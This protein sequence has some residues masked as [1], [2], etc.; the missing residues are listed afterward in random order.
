LR[1]FIEEVCAMLDY[2]GLLAAVVATTTA[3]EE[4]QSEPALADAGSAL[5][6]AA[7]NDPASLHLGALVGPLLAQAGSE[8]PELD[9]LRR[10]AA[11][12]GRGCQLAQGLETARIEFELS[13][14]RND[15]P[16]ALQVLQ[17][18]LDRLAGLHTPVKSL[19]AEVEV[20]RA[21]VDTLAHIASH[22][23]QTDLPS[24]QWDWANLFAGRRGFAFVQAMREG[25][26]G[27]RGRAFAAGAI[28]GYAG[29]VAGSAC[30]GAMVGGPR[31][32]H[33]F[34]DRLARNT[35]GMALR[36]SLPVPS[37]GELSVE[38]RFD[39]R[40]LPILPSDLKAQLSSALSAAYPDRPIPDL[41]VAHQ[42]MIEHLELLTGFALPNLPDPPPIVVD[43]SPE[44][45]TIEA[46]T[47]GAPEDPNGPT[48][49]LGPDTNHDSPGVSSQKKAQGSICGYIL[50]L[51]VTLGIAYLLWCIGRLTT[52]KKCGIEDFV[53]ASSPEEPP[54]GA[55]Q[56]NQQMLEKLR[57]PANANHILDD[58][59]Q[60]QIRI[61]QGFASARSFL[62]VCGLVP[63]NEE[64]LALS[65]FKDLLLPSS[66]TIWPHR[67][68]VDVVTVFTNRPTTPAE[69]PPQTKPFP[70]RRCEWLLHV[71]LVD[72]ESTFSEI[73]FAVL[74]GELINLDLDADRG[75][76]HPAW[77]VASGTSIQD[78]PLTVAVLPFEEQ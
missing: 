68:P 14:A 1:V 67:E 74:R 15:L 54:P 13:L 58:I 72:N 70:N 38:L 22:P 24:S 11:L 77:T 10:T 9:L 71:D 8:P 43:P 28:A 46:Q 44:P 39:A 47:F 56:A 50:L 20:L 36:R 37:L 60:L 78:Q 59:Y 12:W 21:E 65:L 34:R 5:A 26:Q 31:R 6:Q 25:G 51:I 61:W 63:P 45:A 4:A 2:N 64:E 17:M 19:V 7:A 23:R 73:V 40:E 33:R 55:P 49:T 32:L 41:D 52:D 75:R 18:G 66:D 35:L 76:L 62:T 53:G 27:V 42:R 48:I 16:D 69:V 3:F 57:E 30:L 29:H